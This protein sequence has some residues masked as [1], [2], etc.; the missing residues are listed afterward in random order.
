MLDVYDDNNYTD[1]MLALEEVVTPLVV[2]VE[3]SV[4]RGED[5]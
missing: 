5:Y 1:K 2:V 3:T 4:L